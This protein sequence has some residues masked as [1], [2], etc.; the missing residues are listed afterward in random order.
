[1]IEATNESL[2]RYLESLGMKPLYQKETDQI[3]VMME[4]DKQEFPLFFRFFEDADMLQLLLFFPF[5]LTAE[6][7]NTMARMLH[8]INK[9]IDLPGFGMDEALGVVFHRTMCPLVE[10]KIDSRILKT[11]LDAAPKLCHQFYGPLAGTAMTNLSFEELLKKSR[12]E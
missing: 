11:Y 4:V 12:K 6:K 7:L 9:E 1:M 3:Y 10:K 8:F 5:Q 2:T